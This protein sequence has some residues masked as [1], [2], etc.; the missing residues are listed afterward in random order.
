MAVDSDAKIR[1]NVYRKIYSFA[2]KHR[3]TSSSSLFHSASTT[4]PPLDNTGITQTEIRCSFIESG[5]AR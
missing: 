5:K 2:A 3:K 1:Y 4:L